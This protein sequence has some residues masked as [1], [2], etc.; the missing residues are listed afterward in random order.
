MLL[1]R[2]II[3][4]GLSLGVLTR[5]GAFGTSSLELKDTETDKYIG[6]YKIN[7]GFFTKVVCWYNIPNMSCSYY[8]KYFFR[9][10]QVIQYNADGRRNN[11]V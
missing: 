10:V 4:G 6:V 3:I 1:R 11:L 5:F 9:P 7:F 8:N 2:T